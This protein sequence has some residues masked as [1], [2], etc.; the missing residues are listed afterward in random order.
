MY[1]E[2]AILNTPT[3]FTY[4]SNQLFLRGD[5]VEVPLR[6]KK[7]Y[8]YVLKEVNQPPYE[9]KDIISKK[10]HFNEKYQ[11]I[12]EFISKYYF[13]SIGEAA[14]LFYWQVRDEKD[15]LKKE[16]KVDINLT[17]KQKEA[18]EFLKSKDAS[19]L[20]GDTGSGKTEIYIKLIEE[21]INQGKKA[22]FLLP[23]I[24]ITSQ[25]EKRLKKYF[26]LAI[27]HSKITKKKKEEILNNLDKYNVIVGAR[28]CLLYTSPSPRD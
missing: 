14:G 28:S 13:C 12:I 4:K 8:G 25:I 17:E 21:T 7:T 27:W 11:Q 18:F 22:I 15:K 9:C 16:C 6:N 20:F 24:A 2:I 3:I 5:I 1:Y 10:F 23:E 26:N 19:I